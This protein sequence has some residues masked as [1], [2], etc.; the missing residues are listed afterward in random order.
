MFMC[1]RAG[2]HL[3]V[4][5]TNVRVRITE[6]LVAI[7]EMAWSVKNFQWRR[8]N[9]GLYVC[10]KTRLYVCRESLSLFREW[11]PGRIRKQASALPKRIWFGVRNETLPSH[12]NSNS[13]L[14][15]VT[16]RVVL[17]TR[18]VCVIIC[19]GYTQHSF[20]S[21]LTNGTSAIVIVTCCYM[22]IPRLRVYIL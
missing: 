13:K 3:E 12:N 16:D 5:S 14:V 6:S 18:C 15:R 7:F 11:I 20:Y 19:I 10:T 8:D 17:L 2:T 22:R 4:F 21:V 1:S 9:F